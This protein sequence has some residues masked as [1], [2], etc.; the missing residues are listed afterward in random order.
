M[1]KVFSIVLILSALQVSFAQKDSLSSILYWGDRKITFEDFKG[2][3]VQNSQSISEFSYVIGYQTFDKEI[4]NVNVKWIEAYCYMDRYSSWMKEQ[5]KNPTLLLYNQTLFDI[6]EL[7]TRKLQDEINQLKGSSTEI[8]NQ[9]NILLRDYGSRVKGK[10]GVLYSETNGGLNRTAVE[11]WNQKTKIELE[12]QKKNLMPDYSLGRFGLGLSFDIGYGLLTGNSKEY[13]TNNLILAFGFDVAYKPL[14]M[15]LRAILGFNSVKKEFIAEDKTWTTNLNT[16]IAI[17]EIS[18]GYPVYN[19]DKFSITPFAGIGGV[20]FSVIK[21]ENNYSG[22]R[23]LSFA[24]VFGVNIDYMFGR[25]LDL[26]NYFLFKDKSNWVIRTRF[27]AAP[28]KFNDQIKGW[29]FN[30][31]IGIG[32]FS[33]LVEQ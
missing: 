3:P 16:G 20:E 21:N 6:V 14:I 2:V 24:E 1:K 26:I 22:Y 29:S 15:Y 23:I 28:Y 27:T 33:N 8:S 12:Q 10:I 30:L 11:Y 25:N 31:T 18:I 4:D 13:F 17:P 19:N 5:Y 9:L 7:F 32:G